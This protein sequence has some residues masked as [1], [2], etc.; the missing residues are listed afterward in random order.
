MAARGGIVEKE[1]TLA[2]MSCFMIQST[3]KVERDILREGKAI[4]GQG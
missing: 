1:E 2:Q 3:M 4:Y